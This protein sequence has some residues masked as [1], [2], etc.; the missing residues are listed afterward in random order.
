MA[1]GSPQPST[2]PR[3]ILVGGG[4]AN[5]LIALKLRQARPDVELIV[6]EAGP[7][8]GG[9]HT[10][11]FFETDLTPSQ[12][13]LVAPLIAHRWPRYEVR[14]P[15]H[16]RVLPTG[17]A[18]VSAERFSAHLAPLLSGQLRLNTRVAALGPSSVTLEDQTTLAAD[19]V[20][21]ARGP[22]P[23]PELVLGFQKFV[24]LE[25][26]LERPHGLTAPIIMDATVDQEGGYRFVYVLPFDD[27]TCLIEDTRY[28]DGPELDRDAFIRGIRN[29]AAVRGWTIAEVLREED[30]VLPVALEG[31]IQAYWAARGDTPQAGLRAALFHPTT[32]YSLPDA[33]R[34]AER[35][36]ELPRFDAA[37]VGQAVRA[38]SIALWGE[39]GLYRLL[40]RMLFR[41]AEA[42]RRY[43]VMQRFYRL[44]APLIER[45]YAARSTL[46][47]KA[48]ILV[49]K[50]PVPIGRALMCLNERRRL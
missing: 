17:Y 19:A 16:R 45:F 26:R 12:A 27:H 41:A 30:G 43:V 42:D 48:R 1:K 3:L 40:N 6:L 28:T 46:A 2:G 22:A 20:I 13:A 14:F 15:D 50:P 7:T 11:S 4:L 8:L 31:D 21:D 38:H 9:N 34:L 5:G 24:G 10:W 47:D 23:S 18:S 49:G 35:I 39:R 37:T 36:A 32:G 44:P 25:V 29:Y 33:A